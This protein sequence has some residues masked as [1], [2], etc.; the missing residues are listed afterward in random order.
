MRKIAIWERQG[1]CLAK[2]H[3]PNG[4]PLAPLGDWGMSPNGHNPRSVGGDAPKTLYRSLF[5]L[6]LETLRFSK[7]SRGKRGV[8]NICL[9]SEIS[10]RESRK[11]KDAERSIYCMR[12]YI[13]MGHK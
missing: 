3:L 13:R 12:S 5:A 2:I 6:V 9:R 11:K 7:M 1:N 8:A 10:Y 4:P